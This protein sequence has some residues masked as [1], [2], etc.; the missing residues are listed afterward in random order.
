MYFVA[1]LAIFYYKTGAFMKAVVISFFLIFLFSCES[2]HD[3]KTRPMKPESKVEMSS[4]LKK[5]FKTGK[6][7]KVSRVFSEQPHLIFSVDKKGQTPLHIS[8]RRGLDNI[9]KYLI[10]YGAELSAL[11]EAGR[12]PL[13]MALYGGQEG[14]VELLLDKGADLSK[15]D[16][17]GNTGLH[18]GAHLFKD[19]DFFDF[20]EDYKVALD[21]NKQNNLGQTALHIAAKAD[22]RDFLALLLERKVSLS[23]LDSRGNTALSLAADSPKKNDNVCMDL[24]KAGSPLDTVNVDKNNLLLLSIKR[25]KHKLFKALLPFTKNFNVKNDQGKTALHL[26]VEESDFALA[27]LLLDNG[28]DINTQDRE[29]NSV[30][31]SLAFWGDAKGAKFLLQY[32]PTLDLLNNEERQAVHEFAF[33]GKAD[34]M[35]VFV[36]AGAKLDGRCA[37]GQT[38]L[39]LAIRQNKLKVVDFILS[40][41]NAK[42]LLALKNERG[43]TPL[44]MALSS[45]QS[46]EE[47]IKKLIDAGS[48]VN[49]ENIY[50]ESPLHDAVKQ[51]NL[52]WVKVLVENGAVINKKDYRANTALDWARK[53]QS[54]K[55]IDFLQAKSK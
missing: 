45:F 49:T 16:A 44:H 11:D 55:I 31:H 3:I 19:E 4:A 2:T 39:H 7:S 1:T 5:A 27:K 47:L 40:Q 24:V 25:R 29:G 52:A 33:W 6:I 46:S 26:A 35:K 41:K 34:V 38:A 32:K 14:T 20:Y 54:H 17:A 37:N 43:F 30:L 10:K 36:E 53:R 50:K 15:E 13:H 9:S 42:A 8:A 18:Y 22:N 48:D 51:E 12:T 23:L 21:L 28:A